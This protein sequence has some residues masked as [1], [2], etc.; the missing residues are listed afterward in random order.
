MW[1]LYKGHRKYSEANKT[2]H[3][4]ECGRNVKFGNL[5]ETNREFL[6]FENVGDTSEVMYVNALDTLQMLVF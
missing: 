4:R 2:C 1:G 3:V 6:K 5:G